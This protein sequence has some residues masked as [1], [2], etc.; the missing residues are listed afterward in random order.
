MLFYIVTRCGSSPMESVFTSDRGTNVKWFTYVS[1]TRSYSCSS[2]VNKWFMTVTYPG[3]GV[4]FR[5][6]CKIVQMTIGFIVS[7]HSSTHLSVWNNLAPTGWVFIK[8]DIWV[9]SKNL[10][11]KFMF[12]YNQTIITGT[13]REHQYTFFIISHLFLLRMWNISDSYCRENQ[14]TFYVQ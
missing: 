11:R 13:L 10:S 3:C 14:N 12:R 4:I 1:S 9:F 7:V 2:C 8:F 5:R 6:V